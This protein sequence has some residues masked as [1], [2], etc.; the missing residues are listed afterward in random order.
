MPLTPRPEDDTGSPP[1]PPR[2]QVALRRWRGRRDVTPRLARPP[3]PAGRPSRS[4]RPSRSGRPGPPPTSPPRRELSPL[5]APHRCAPL[6]SP[7]ACAA[8]GRFPHP[9]ASTVR[10]RQPA[11]SIPP[12]GP[13][14][15][16]GAR[17]APFLRRRTGFPPPVAMVMPPAPSP[18]ALS[19]QRGPAAAAPLASGGQRRP[20]PSLAPE[21]PHG[22]ARRWAAPAGTN[23]AGVGR[24]GGHRGRPRS[25]EVPAARPLPPPP[26]A[27][28]SCAQCEERKHPEPH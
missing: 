18:F 9:A 11:V 14:H 6:P 20:G 24:S 19:P 1:P 13:A 4:A 8:T 27:P 23:P 21:P 15:A 2:Q 10:M 22:Q 7:S 16:P 26:C 3:L 17:A 5:L 25:G 28:S 12:A